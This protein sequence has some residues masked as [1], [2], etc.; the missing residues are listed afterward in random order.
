VTAS[1]PGETR[2]SPIAPASSIP[3]L[4][5]AGWR[6]R[7][8]VVAGI[9]TRAGGFDVGLHSSQPTG[10]VMSRWLALAGGAV[11][12][13]SAV[14][15]S[16]QVHANRVA[17]HRGRHVGILLADGFDGHTTEEDGILLAVTVADCVPVYLIAPGTRAITLLHAGWRGVAAGILETGIRIV[18]ERS[19]PSPADVVMHCGVSICGD[20]YEVGPEVHMA[21]NGTR[22]AG[23]CPLDLRAALVD[24]AR[25]MGVKEV[26]VSPWCTAHDSDRFFSHR[27]SHGSDGR[28][29]AYLGRP[30]LNG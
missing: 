18:C 23:P 11:P 14:A 28:M 22:V 8:G 20:C 3:R 2:E 29:V 19:G 17:T 9:T 26:T 6:E 27:G 15:V 12:G 10:E 24:R 30:R 1:A 25:R 4:E 13:F 5:L 16:R 21:V 7:F